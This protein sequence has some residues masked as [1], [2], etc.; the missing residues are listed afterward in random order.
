LQ[1]CQIKRLAGRI[2][3]NGMVCK[4]SGD[5]LKADMLISRHNQVAVDF[6]GKHQYIVSDTDF[7][8]P[9]QFLLGP[10]PSHRVMGAAEDGDFDPGIPCF[11]FKIINVHL[12][13]AVHYLQWILRNCPAVSN[14]GLG[15]GIINR[16]LDEDF[17][18]GL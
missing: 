11:F 8:E 15:K 18:S 3:R 1:A 17:V 13:A 4:F 5:A 12:I 2:G 6:I 14:D 7:P 16:G 9:F 10:D